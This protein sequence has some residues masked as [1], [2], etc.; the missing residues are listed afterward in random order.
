MNKL[1]ALAI[2]LCGLPTILFSQNGH[3]WTQQYGTRSM[4]LSGSVIGGVEDLGAVYYNPARLGLIEN[5]AFLISADVYQWN[6]LKMENALGDNNS[7]SSSEFDGVPSLAAGTFKVGFMPKDHF[8]Y[9]VLSR[10]RNDLSFNYRE[11]IEGD[12]IEAWPG[13][14]IFEGEINLVAKAKEEWFGGSWSRPLN[15][16]FSLGMSG[17][18]TINNQKKGNT[19]RL[20]ALEDNGNVATYTYSR[21]Y[22]LKSYGLIFKLAAAYQAKNLDLGL[23]I[24]TPSLQLRGN[25]N[26]NYQYY[27]SGIEGVS[28]MPDSYA[29]SYQNGLDLTHKSPLS[30]GVGST[31]HL[32][33]SSIHFSAEYFHKI[34]EYTVFQAADHTMQSNPDSIISFLVVDEFQSIINAGL[35]LEWF[36]SEKVSAYASACTDL[37]AVKGSPTAFT[38]NKPKTNNSTIAADNYN[39]GGGVVLTFKGADITLG[40]THTGSKSDFARPI[41]FPDDGS[42]DDS[43][44][45]DPEKTGTLKWSRWTFVFSFSVPFLKEYAEEKLEKI[46][47][48]NK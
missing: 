9:A 5:P 34:P 40:A 18:F 15:N 2:I 38:E 35:G 31:F 23:T 8:A 41:S 37:S 39:Y 46:G 29:N 43:E 28:S 48:K 45:F 21:D 26:Y 25:A 7:L 14:E 30:I 33:K 10:Q 47:N 44:I 11:Q 32:G 36:F 42:G 27:F 22:S 3:F 6:T 13:E 24:T 1:T 4:L 19:I 20:R 16:R 12:V 17:F